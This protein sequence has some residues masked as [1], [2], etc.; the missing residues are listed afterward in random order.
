MAIIAH[1]L[2]LHIAKLFRHLIVL[3]LSIQLPPDDI[4]IIERCIAYWATKALES[5]VISLHF[6]QARLMDCVATKQ[7][8]DLCSTLEQ[9]LQTHWAILVH[10]IYDTFMTFL[11]PYGVAT[12]TRFAVKIIFASS[13]A[14]YTTLVTVEDSFVI[15]FIIPKIACGA[16]I[17]PERD[18]ACFVHTCWARGLSKVTFA[19]DNFLYG[20]SIHLM[21]RCVSMTV[22]TPCYVSATRSHYLTSATIVLASICI[23][24]RHHTGTS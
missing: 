22:P 19:T 3:Y 8:G 10:R 1:N 14:T 13:Y 21:C 6:Y 5:A 16:K 15:A 18:A 23:Y 11:Y 17:F 7:Y 9:I 2:N 4:I 20:I 12:S 24:H